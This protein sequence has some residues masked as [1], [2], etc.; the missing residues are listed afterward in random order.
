MLHLGD[1]IVDFDTGGGT[2]TLTPSLTPDFESSASAIPPLRH[3]MTLQYS[4]KSIFQSILKKNMFFLMRATRF[5]V[6]GHAGARPSLSEVT[7]RE[8]KRIIAKRE[9]E[10]LAVVAAVFYLI[11]GNFIDGAID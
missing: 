11:F 1:F 5:C 4:Q 8:E 2:R 3:G 7:E 9:M 10:E 6:S